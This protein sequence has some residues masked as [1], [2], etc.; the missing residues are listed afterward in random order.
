MAEPVNLGH[1][2]YRCDRGHVLSPTSPEAIRMERDFLRAEAERLKGCLI[3][4]VTGRTCKAIEGSA[5]VVA[6]LALGEPED[7]ASAPQMLS[8][9]YDGK[10][11]HP[12]HGHHYHCANC[13]E[14]SSYQG[15]MNGMP[16]A[17][18]CAPTANVQPDPSSAPFVHEHVD[19]C[20]L[21][22][23]GWGTDW[24]PI[25]LEEYHR[26]LSPTKSPSP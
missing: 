6:M 13:G 19:Y 4:L 22:C 9:E 20:A 25:T 2:E 5:L 11:C 12:S 7:P 24:T 18:S 26:R 16:P 1:G 23:P 21:L 8:T 3:D 17:F 10:G 14:V 15:H